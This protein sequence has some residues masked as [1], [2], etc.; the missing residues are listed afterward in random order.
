MKVKRTMPINTK[1]NDNAKSCISQE[2]ASVMGKKLCVMKTCH[3]GSYIISLK[4]YGQFAEIWRRSE[5]CAKITQTISAKKCT[6]RSQVYK[7]IS[8]SIF[9]R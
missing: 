8:P 5:F 7:A 1:M 4:L 3:R 6:K 2:G 9:S